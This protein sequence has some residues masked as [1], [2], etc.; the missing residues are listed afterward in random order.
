MPAPKP[1]KRTGA[2]DGISP[3]SSIL[4][5]AS[6]IEADDVLPAVTM[7]SATSACGAPSL[8]AIAS[9]IRRLAWGGPDAA[10]SVGSIPP[11]ARL[12][13]APAAVRDTDLVGHLPRAAPHHGP[14]PRLVGVGHRADHHGAGAV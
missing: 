4:A 2:P 11:P 13:G 9:T 7:S 14:D 12:D 10:S 3:R 5:R 6:G 1:S 8:R